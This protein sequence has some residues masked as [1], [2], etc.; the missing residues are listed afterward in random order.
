VVG[1]DQQ[2]GV[3]GN[4]S[5]LDYTVGIFQQP[6]IPNPFVAKLISTKTSADGSIE[7][8]N[9]VIQRKKD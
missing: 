4:G 1:W 2:Y 9:W 3:P 6:G 5:P 8:S 7:T